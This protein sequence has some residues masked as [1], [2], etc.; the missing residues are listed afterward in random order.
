MYKWV[1]WN[2]R[3]IIAA[4]VIFVCVIIA[5]ALSSWYG[6]RKSKGE[7]NET[8]LSGRE[9]NNLPSKNL[10]NAPSISN[11]SD[12][13]G[14]PSPLFQ[15]PSAAP[16]NIVEEVTGNSTVSISISPSFV[17]SYYQRQPNM[18][19]SPL[20]Q[21]NS[22]NF[23]SMATSFPS[24]TPSVAPLP[25]F[26]LNIT[27]ENVTL[28]S[29]P[30]LQPSVVENNITFPFIYP[31]TMPSPSLQISDLVNETQFKSF[32]IIDGTEVND[33]AG[34][35]VSTTAS[36]DFVA[37]GFRE[38]DGMIEK[39]GLVRV[40]KR[41]GDVY[42]PR[43][44]DSMFGTSTLD[45]FGASVSISNDGNRVAVGASSSSFSGMEKNGEVKIYEYSEPSDSW[46][47]LGN[48]IQGL[49]DK[50][51][52]GYSVVISGNGL[53]VAAGSPRGNAG[54]GTASVYQ[55]N[56]E[57]WDLV[58]EAFFGNDF[59]DRAGF[60]V[61]LSDDG[62]TLA[63]GALFASSI[64]DGQDDCIKCGTVSV[65]KYQESSA[66]S[67]WENFGQL[68]VGSGEW[69]HFGHSLALSGDG[70]RMVVGANGF[71]TAEKSSVGS[72]EIF[73][74]QNQNWT[75]LKTLLLAEE[76]EQTGSNVAMSKDGKW[77]ACSKTGIKNGVVHVLREYGSKTWNVTEEIFSSRPNSTSFGT[78]VSVANDGQVIAVGAPLHNSSTGYFELYNRPE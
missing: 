61:S 67:T 50:E 8:P 73:E 71:S 10:T 49:E 76:Q 15:K 55:Y 53:R 43:G 58:G 37:V 19:L 17:P 70:Q 5:I 48:S 9:E 6:T 18:S 77:V 54:T 45:E 29:T 16:S 60:S 69:S 51:R 20:S 75:S 40:Y 57:D 14:N 24:I 74:L 3:K 65:Y 1:V 47:Q 21:T 12:I 63:I 38:A 4:I 64:I 32:Q 72:C 22:T 78:S 34:M 62:N 68:L 56:G 26:D 39:S 30:S 23:P 33:F 31:S 27:Q 36:G 25:T 28:T 46:V 2:I 66:S 52:F 44:I 41:I 13:G 11:G 35:S 7:S 42:S 59:G